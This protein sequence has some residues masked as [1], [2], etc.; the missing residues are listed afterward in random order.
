MQLGLTH[1]Q[2]ELWKTERENGAEAIFDETVTDNSPKLIE[3]GLQATDS[4]SP[5]ASGRKSILET[6]REMAKK[7]MERSSE[8]LS[9]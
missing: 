9:D 3:R 7:H 4:G 2:L 5:R 6:D 8:V 1:T